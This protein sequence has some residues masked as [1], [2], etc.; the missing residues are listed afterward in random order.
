MRCYL[1]NKFKI[2]LMIAAI[3]A[4]TNINSTKAKKDNSAKMNSC[5]VIYD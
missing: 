5:I 1:L 2:P 3:M 4:I